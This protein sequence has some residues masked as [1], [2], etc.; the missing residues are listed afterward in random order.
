MRRTKQI[1]LSL[2]I[3]AALLLLAWSAGSQKP[4]EETVGVL[5]ARVDIPAGSRVTSDQLAVVMIPSSL[6]IDGYFENQVE[7]VGMWTS[8]S[9]SAG[10]L[11]SRSR[12]KPDA[13]GLSYPD[14]GPGRRLIT[15]KLEPADAN[16]YWLAAGNRID[17]YLIPR[18][19]DTEYEIQILEQIR[20]MAILDEGSGAAVTGFASAAPVSGRLICLDLNHEQAFLI[21]S[22]QGSHDIRLSAI[23]ESTPD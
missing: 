1:L 3:T 6:L 22:L 9:L 15:L 14:P 5:A 13:I 19:R 23:N 21:I 17:L 11:V 2:V 7:V 12:L 4:A 8:V 10:E 16:G 20:I 18:N